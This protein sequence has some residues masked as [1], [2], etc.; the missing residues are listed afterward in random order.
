M[1]AEAVKL[2]GWQ[3]ASLV[4]FA[5]MTVFYGMVVLVMLQRKGVDATTLRSGVRNPSVLAAAFTQQGG[6]LLFNIGLGF[7]NDTGG[8]VIVALSACYPILTMLLAFLYLKERL[9][10]IALVGGMLAIAGILTLSL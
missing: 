1:L 9:P 7:D 10:L 3:A 2:L 5:T 8:S 4:Q 6:A